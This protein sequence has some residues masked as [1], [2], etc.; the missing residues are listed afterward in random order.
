MHMVNIMRIT[1]SNEMSTQNSFQIA[2]CYVSL[3]DVH[4]SRKE[5]SL[6]PNECIVSFN[7]SY[8]AF[9]SSNTSSF[10]GGGAAGR[11]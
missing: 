4:I 9:G 7:S 8:R 1:V 3:S 10:V 6:R 5:N 2:F 11:D